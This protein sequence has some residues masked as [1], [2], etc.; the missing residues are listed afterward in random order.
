MPAPENAPREVIEAMCRAK[1]EVSCNGFCQTG[2]LY[3]SSAEELYQIIVTAISQATGQVNG[4][5]K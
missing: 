5:G 2:Q 1:F 3:P 4:D